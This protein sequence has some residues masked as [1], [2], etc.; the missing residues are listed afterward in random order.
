M[1]IIPLQIA[2]CTI[3]VAI[4]LFF[5]NVSVQITRVYLNIHVHRVI[6]EQC[7][8]ISLLSMLWTRHSKPL[9]TVT[10]D[11]VKEVVTKVWLLWIEPRL[12]SFMFIMSVLSWSLWHYGVKYTR[13][14]FA[15]FNVKH[16]HEVRDASYR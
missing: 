16:L 3:Y 9:S 6:F 1:N 15:G 2:M 4:F 7:N 5:R 11:L 8:P 13:V 12:Q 10:F 14:T